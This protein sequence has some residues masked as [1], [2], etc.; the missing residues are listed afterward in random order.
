MIKKL[1]TALY[2]DE[3]ILCFHED[4]G[5]AVSLCNEKGILSIDFNNINVD[6]TNHDEDN[7]E[8]IIHIKVLAWHIKFEKHKALKK[9]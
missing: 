1:F 3:N 4:S 5:D 9:R 7:L 2:A 6:D 8:N